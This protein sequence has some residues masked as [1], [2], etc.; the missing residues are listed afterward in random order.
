MQVEVFGYKLT[1]DPEAQS[2]KMDHGTVWQPRTV[3]MQEGD[4]LSIKFELREPLAAE[5]GFGI[6]FHIHETERTPAWKFWNKK[7]GYTGGVFMG[8]AIYFVVLVIAKS[9]QIFWG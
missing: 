4:T 9:I 3:S 1:K 8:G 2:H 6:R 5:D 7:S